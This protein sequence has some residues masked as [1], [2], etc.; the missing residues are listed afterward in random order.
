MTEKLIFLYLI[1]KNLLKV[2]EEKQA[3]VDWV[4]R[5]S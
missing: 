4:S 3:D 1:S 2:N 5:R